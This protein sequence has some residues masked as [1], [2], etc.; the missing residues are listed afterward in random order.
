MNW[1]EESR[2]DGPENDHISPHI[3]DTSACCGLEYQV[4]KAWQRG[5]RCKADVQVPACK[6]RREQHAPALLS[7]EPGIT[8]H[9]EW[10]G[11]ATSCLIARKA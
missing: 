2:R 1:H 11:K 7:R 3:T 10:S 9:G 5:T 8:Q 6:A 4:M